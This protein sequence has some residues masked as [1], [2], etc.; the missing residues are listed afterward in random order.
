MIYKQVIKALAK[1]NIRDKFKNYKY[2]INKLRLS[3]RFEDKKQFMAKA[4]LSYLLLK[5]GEG[6]LTEADLPNGRIIDLLRVKRNGEIIIYDFESNRMNNEPIEGIEEVK[7]PVSKMPQKIID[8]LAEF[9]RWI[10]EF[11]DDGYE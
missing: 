4:M 7:I 2:S 9:E 3:K 11:I 8:G 10:M 5:R 1:N 6:I